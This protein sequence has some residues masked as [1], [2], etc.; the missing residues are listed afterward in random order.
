[1][2]REELLMKHATD[3]ELLPPSFTKDYIIYNG[4]SQEKI[5]CKK[6]GVI[7]RSMQIDESIRPELVM[8]EGKRML[9]S[10]VTFLPL[11]NY[12]E[13]TVYSDNQTQHVTNCCVHCLNN[14]TPEDVKAFLV[15][16]TEQLIKDAAMAGIPISDGLLRT[17]IERDPV[18]WE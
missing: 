18:F 14:L 5:L 7:I 1:M 17:L 15:I 6:C 11:A 3:L 16:D 13:L 10:R 8:H 4:R 9:Q 2:T 12:T